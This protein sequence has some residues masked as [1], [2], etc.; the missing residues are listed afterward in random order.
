MAV[1][2]LVAIYKIALK[3]ALLTLNTNNL[4]GQ[5]M[6]DNIYWH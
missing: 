1:C 2:N 5:V 6:A 4:L 3:R